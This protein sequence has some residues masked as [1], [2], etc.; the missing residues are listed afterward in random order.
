MSCVEKV[1]ERTDAG[2][3]GE[4]R[5]VKEYP[6]TTNDDDTFII[7]YVPIARTETYSAGGLLSVV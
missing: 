2:R 1:G 3:E 6:A 4:A 5:G 7:V